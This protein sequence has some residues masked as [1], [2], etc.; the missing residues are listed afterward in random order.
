MLSLLTPL[1]TTV[2]LCPLVLAH[3]VDSRAIDPLF[4]FWIQEAHASDSGRIS[5]AL[6]FST[7]EY[8]C[9][10]YTIP[11][12]TGIDSGTVTI[13]LGRPMAPTMCLTAFGPAQ[14]ECKLK[15]SKG[16]HRVLFKSDKRVDEY[17]LTVRESTIMLKKRV[18]SFCRPAEVA[19]PVWDQVADGVWEC[20]V[21]Q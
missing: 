4:Y 13:H 18:A 17:L 3:R 2:M 16:R 9:M 15:L 8:E 6:H 20:R 5:L 7:G 21:G 10:N 19:P 12:T 1:I 14:G 11:I